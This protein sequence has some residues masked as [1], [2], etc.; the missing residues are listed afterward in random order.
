MRDLPVML[1]TALETA[2]ILR[3]DEGRSDELALKALSRL[4]ENGLLR[5]AM[6]G[7]Y[8]RFSPKEIARYID[9]R[10]E[11]YAEVRS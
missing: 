9:A 4:I 6:V 8:R 11:N 5:P 2:R 7:K 3:L 1:H 10:T